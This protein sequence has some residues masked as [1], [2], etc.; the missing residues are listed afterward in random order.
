ML[1]HAFQ[2]DSLFALIFRITSGQYDPLPAHYSKDLVALLASLLEVDP[3][4]RPTCRSLLC[5]PFI[6]QH[7]VHTKNKVCKALPFLPSSSY[8][9]WDWQECT[10]HPHMM[11]DRK[12]FLGSVTALKGWWLVYGD[13]FADHGRATHANTQ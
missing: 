10:E 9:C 6:Q 13:G 8:A 3:A 4:Q 11:C 12:P 7:I 1:K 5:S 2:A